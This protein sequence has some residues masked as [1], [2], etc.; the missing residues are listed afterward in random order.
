MRVIEW[1]E[2]R[3]SEAKKTL[4]LTAVIICLGTVNYPKTIDRRKSG[5]PREVNGVFHSIEKSRGIIHINNNNRNCL[6]TRKSQISEEIVVCSLL[7]MN[8]IVPGLLDMYSRGQHKLNKSM[9]KISRNVQQSSFWCTQLRNYIPQKVK[10][11]FNL[12]RNCICI[13]LK[14]QP[15]IKHSTQT[16][17][18]APLNQFQFPQ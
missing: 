9:Y 1:Y 4:S 15:G 13:S 8:G 18:S 6:R 17:L 14:A 3:A 2:R 5:R 12:L 16:L 11:L 10:T 7:N